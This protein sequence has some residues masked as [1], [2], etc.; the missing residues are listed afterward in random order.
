MVIHGGEKTKKIV[1]NHSES[2]PCLFKAVYKNVTFG[3]TQEN[4]IILNKSYK[5]IRVL[6]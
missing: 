2:Q 6:F 5:E 4:Q 1:C 3:T